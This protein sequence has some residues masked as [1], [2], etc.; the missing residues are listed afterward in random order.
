MRK[1]FDL[2]IALMLA[3]LTINSPAHAGTCNP[4]GICYAC[5][6]C[7]A[8]GNC[9]KRGGT[10]S[11]CTGQGG[12][13][14]SGSSS[15]TSSGPSSSYSSDYSG[16]YN[17]SPSSFDG[18]AVL[19]TPYGP[20]PAELRSPTP[21]PE[22]TPTNEFSGQVVGV[23]D[24]DTISVMRNGRA[25]KVRLD[26]PESG[27]P[28]GNNAKQFTSRAAFGQ[29]VKVFAKELDRYGRT[30]GSVLLPD[31]SWLEYG[32]V[33]N[34]LGWWYR[35]YAPDDEYFPKFEQEARAAKIGLWSDKNAVA[36]W[37]WR[38]GK[39]ASKTVTKAP[40]ISSIPAPGHS[41]TV[42]SDAT[43]STDSSSILL[44]WIVGGLGVAGAGMI[45]MALRRN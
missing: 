21:T 28:F 25:V 10:C 20:A 32:L 12:G 2:V 43:P 41:L 40:Q 38:R 1:I 8:C 33:Q 34:G 36:P 45:G 42:P 19:L 37:E 39:R 27:Q 26:C 29:T 16:D 18:P 5:K 44:F 31:N 4:N 7:S 35:Q 22:P 15:S 3:C 17:R 24:G 30:V 13:Q 14:S 23:S 9:A 6:N 11:V